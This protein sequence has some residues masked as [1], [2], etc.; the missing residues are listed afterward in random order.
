MPNLTKPRMIDC[1]LG[2]FPAGI[3]VGTVVDDD[4]LERHA[5]REGLVDLADQRREIAGLVAHRHD[6]GDP[7]LHHDAAARPHTTAAGGGNLGHAAFR[8]VGLRHG[9]PHCRM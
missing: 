5:A 3:V 7:G 6:D 2:H 4:D 1:K 9:G 8:L